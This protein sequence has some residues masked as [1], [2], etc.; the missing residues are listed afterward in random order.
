MQN[1]LLKIAKI[2]KS[3]RKISTLKYPKIVPPKNTCYKK[4]FWKAF[5]KTK[6]SKKNPWKMS[7]SKIPLLQN[8]L[9]SWLQKISWKNVS[10]KN[11]FKN[12]EKWKK[13]K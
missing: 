6:F 3:S 2:E 13:V 8:I 12:T 1:I 9:I 5:L 10:L 4:I 7:F 11:I